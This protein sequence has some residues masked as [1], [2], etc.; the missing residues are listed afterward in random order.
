MRD[1]LRVFNC[2]WFDQFRSFHHK[3]AVHQCLLKR[4]RELHRQLDLWP[5]DLTFD[6]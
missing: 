5:I 4:V 6:L 1:D 2:E 3:L